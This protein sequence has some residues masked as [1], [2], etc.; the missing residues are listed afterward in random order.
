MKPQTLVR[1]ECAN[2]RSGDGFCWQQDEPCLVCDG[3][4]CSYFEKAVLPLADQKTSFDLTLQSKRAEARARYIK[5]HNITTHTPD[6]D[7]ICPKCGKPLPSSRARGRCDSCRRKQNR[8]TSRQRMR[9]QR[10]G[11][12]KNT[13]WDPC[14]QRTYDTRN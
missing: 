8:E 7:A 13:V 14:Q 11:V 9:K 12:T 2:Y 5:S 3:K 10:Q 1:S 4:R 6:E